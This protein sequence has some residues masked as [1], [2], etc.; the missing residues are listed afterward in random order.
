MNIYDSRF[1]ELPPKQEKHYREGENVESVYIE[2]ALFYT[3]LN[4][5]EG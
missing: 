1:V 2:I 3:L 5:K 4:S